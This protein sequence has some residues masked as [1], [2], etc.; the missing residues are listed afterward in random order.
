[1][2][3]F[4]VTRTN[5]KGNSSNRMIIYDIVDKVP[6]SIST[7][8]TVPN[9][10][11]A[12]PVKAIAAIKGIGTSHEKVKAVQ[13]APVS[14][15][16]SPTRGFENLRVKTAKRLNTAKVAVEK[17]TKEFMNA[18]RISNKALDH[19]KKDSDNPSALEAYVAANSK[20]RSTGERRAAAM[21]ERNA[22]EKVME[23][24]EREAQEKYNKSLT[25]AAS[26]GRR[27][28]RKRTHR[29]H[30]THRK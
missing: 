18:S 11:S 15:V 8:T 29:T 26:G 22:A 28:K 1:M 21:K 30:R 4:T 7:P 6:L 23:T 2:V 14:S 24:E 17:E 3:R 9:R 10:G 16:A 25:V 20:T 5:A 27:T 13:P 19:L 12:V